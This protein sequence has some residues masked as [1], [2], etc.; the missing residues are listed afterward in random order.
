MDKYLTPKGHIIRP[1][2]VSW[3][4][5]R[6]IGPGGQYV[7]KASSAMILTVNLAKSGLSKYQVGLL[8]QA[9]G[10][11]LSIRCPDSGSRWM[12]RSISWRRAATKIDYALRP[13]K[14]RKATKPSQAAQD[15]R[16]AEKK[17]DSLQKQQ[18][19][20]IED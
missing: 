16:L 19:R 10:G 7:D 15:R 12:S 11:D 4:T 17:K 9:F 6:S 5:T 3:T 14:D 20:F 13:I 18:R 2:A 1:E 8:S